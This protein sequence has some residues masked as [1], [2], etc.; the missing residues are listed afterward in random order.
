MCLPLGVCWG[1]LSL[2]CLRAAVGG[3]LACVPV[4]TL[5]SWPCSDLGCG[6]VRWAFCCLLN[7]HHCLKY[8]GEFRKSPELEILGFS[9]HRD[10]PVNTFPRLSCGTVVCVQS[11]SALGELCWVREFLGLKKSL[12]VVNLNH[13]WRML[14]TCSDAAKL[15]LP[16]V[17]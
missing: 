17:V 11:L 8:S 9:K 2:L 6:Q 1:L 13:L 12:Q 14:G 7:A 4:Q 15:A 16:L 5:L 3:F 10:P